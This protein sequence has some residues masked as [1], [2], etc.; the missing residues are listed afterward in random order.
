MAQQAGTVSAPTN[1]PRPTTPAYHVTVVRP[2]NIPNSYFTAGR[3][4]ELPGTGDAGA[5]AG[6]SPASLNWP[7][8]PLPSYISQGRAPSPNRTQSAVVP[9]PLPTLPVR[10]NETASMPPP[11]T[12][13]Q[14]SP[15]RERL[16]R[17]NTSPARQWRQPARPS[18][19]I[20]SGQWM[21]SSRSSSSDQVDGPSPS[22]YYTHP[23][24]SRD[25]TTPR[26][27]HPG[28]T[29]FPNLG[30]FT[31]PGRPLP[32]MP[33]PFIPPVPPGSLTPSAPASVW[34]TLTTTPGTRR[35][36][37]LPAPP[38]AHSSRATPTLPMR[39]PR[40]PRRGTPGGATLS[41]ARTPG[42]SKTRVYNDAIAPEGQPQTP[43]D[44][45]ESRHRSRYHQ[46]YTMPMEH[47]NTPRDRSEERRVGKECPV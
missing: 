23:T 6:A 7:R 40:T 24:T 38:N 17:S 3:S 26:H 11:Q 45:P 25:D 14:N 43:E 34:R 5:G 8:G 31:H 20:L 12:P 42:S 36:E 47:R 19:E 41:G 27:P 9:R 28:R 10:R 39:L 46:N 13:I 30:S 29:A 16:W 32:P 37:R 33:Q 2:A 15:S 18:G 22:P 21:A 44:L 4:S 1:R 35:E